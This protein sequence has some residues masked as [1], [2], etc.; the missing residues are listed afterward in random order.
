MCREAVSTSNWLSVSDWESTQNEW[1]RT[2]SVMHHTFDQFNPSSN[3]HSR[4]V[5]SG[6]SFLNS[7]TDASDVMSSSSVNIRLLCGSDLMESFSKPGL[8]D[9]N[10]L[11]IIAGLYGITCI[12]RQ[13]SPSTSQI[14]QKHDLLSLYQGNIHSIENPF[15]NEIS[16]TRV[17]ES[18]SRGYS[19]KYL[20]PDSVNDYISS[21]KL[22]Q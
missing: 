6:N 3:R 14:V 18:L 1:Q 22:Y 5:S 13:G 19:V 17:R 11:E 7:S 20:I 15:Q 12:S 8:W 16:S 10:D 21:K 2:V 9:L 4:F